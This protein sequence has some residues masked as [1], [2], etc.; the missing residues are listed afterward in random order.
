MPRARIVGPALAGLVMGAW[1]I[2]WCFALNTL[3][4]VPTLLVLIRLPR[5]SPPAQAN[6]PALWEDS[7]EG[8]RYVL[9]EKSL[10]NVLLAVG[11]MSIFG[12]NFSVLLPVL[13]KQNLCLF[14]KP[15]FDCHR[16]FG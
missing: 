8:L 11:L 1:G 13:V 10:R 15:R 4:F 14:G 12:F 3:S 2:G 5:P 7:K 16:R 6:Q 9:K